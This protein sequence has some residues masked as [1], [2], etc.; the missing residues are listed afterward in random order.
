LDL[1]AGFGIE[2]LEVEDPAVVVDLTVDDS[3][4]G[5]IGIGDYIEFGCSGKSF[6][7]YLVSLVGKIVDVA[8]VVVEL[9]VAVAVVGDCCYYCYL[10]TGNSVNLVVAAADIVDLEA[11]AG[12]YVEDT[13]AAKVVAVAAADVGI[14]YFGIVDCCFVDSGNKYLVT[15]LFGIADYNYCC[16]YFDNYSWVF[17]PFPVAA[18]VDAVDQKGVDLWSVS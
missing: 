12:C 14:H 16:C 17:G 11:A 18:V 6:C 9:M 2:C 5:L 13:D 1:V 3:V 7:N 4:V 8:A 10:D 15:L